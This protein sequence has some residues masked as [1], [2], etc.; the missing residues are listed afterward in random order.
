[1]KRTK[2]LNWTLGFLIGVPISAV[3]SAD[4]IAQTS[5]SRPMVIGNL[6]FVASLTGDQPAGIAISDSG[7][8]FVTFPRHDGVVAFTVGEIK[9]GRPVAYPTPEL[10]RVAV[11]RPAES[12]FSVQTVQVD[13]SNH[14][15]MLDT[16]TL[17]FGKPPVKG[18]PKLVEVDLASNRPVRT[19][20]LPTEALV[21]TSALK[22]F[23]FDFHRGQGGTAFITDSAPGSEALI[24]LDL[25]SGHAMRRLTGSAAISA[26][27]GQTPIVGFEPLVL[28][29][30]GK[31]KAWLVGINGLELSAD[32]KTLYFSA[33]TGRRLYSIGTGDLSD[34]AVGNDQVVGEIADIGDIGV[35]GHFSLDV[36]GGF[37]FMDM[38]Q[39]AVYRRTSDGRVHAVVVDPRLIWPDTIALGSDKY[40]YVTTSQNDLRPE[41][42]DG[43]DLR[44]RPYGLYRV[45]VGSKPVQARER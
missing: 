34:P 43:K 15:W 37:Y 10:N 22:D 26:R 2:C 8:L 16:G 4:L 31:L 29:K 39:N 23:R 13:A 33:F 18:A 32:C 35:A 20:L 19:I 38:E 14:L 36:D 7:R 44:Q 30:G 5:P 3:G 28:M 27:G 6:E 11:D 25:A 42:H 1:M 21:P 9:E 40:L 45:F 24:V 41:F 17:Q 12:L